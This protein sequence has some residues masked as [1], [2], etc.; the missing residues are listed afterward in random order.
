MDDISCSTRTD[1]AHE[2]LSHI[3]T[4]L[5]SMVRRKGLRL[6]PKKQSIALGN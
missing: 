5:H 3:L 2:Q 1:M 4:R 6:N